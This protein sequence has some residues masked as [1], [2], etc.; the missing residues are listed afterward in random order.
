MGDDEADGSDIGVEIGEGKVG[1]GVVSDS[2]G[3]SGV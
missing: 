2:T 1:N 3:V